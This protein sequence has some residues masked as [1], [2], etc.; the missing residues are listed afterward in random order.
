MNALA[1][2]ERSIVHISLVPATLNRRKSPNSLEKLVVIEIEGLDHEASAMCFEALDRFC[3]SCV[4]SAVEACYL[5]TSRAGFR[6]KKPAGT[7]LNPMCE[8]GITGH[9]SGRGM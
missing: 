3:S 9:S 1:F 4:R 5:G 2:G 6:V 8:A 7:S